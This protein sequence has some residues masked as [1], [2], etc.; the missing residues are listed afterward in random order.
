MF[1]ELKPIQNLID[2]LEDGPAVVDL[3]NLK[4]K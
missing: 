1:T 4:R 2:I 3:H